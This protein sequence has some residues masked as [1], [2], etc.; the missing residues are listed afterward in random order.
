VVAA[1]VV[2]ATSATTTGAA[3]VVAAAGASVAEVVAGS[4]AGVVEVVEVGSGAGAGGV[5][6]VDGGGGGGVEDETEDG[7]VVVSGAAAVGITTT[8]FTKLTVVA[9]VENGSS[10]SVTVTYTISVVISVTYSFL[11]RI[12]EATD[13]AAQKE[14]KMIEE[15][16]LKLEFDVMVGLV[17]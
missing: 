9:E 4:G 11:R 7:A 5:E 2:V 6:V 16:I 17:W 15:R 10:P 14:A 13:R 8:V 1:A 12:G 3:V